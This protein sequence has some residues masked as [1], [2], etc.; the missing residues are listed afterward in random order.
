M[1]TRNSL[2]VLRS[3]TQHDAFVSPAQSNNANSR[4]RLVELRNEVG[5]GLVLGFDAT[6]ETAK[7]VCLLLVRPRGQL[8]SLFRFLV[9]GKVF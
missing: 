4:M 7:P 9:E 2:Y 1:T 5:N 6:G 3:L 8:H